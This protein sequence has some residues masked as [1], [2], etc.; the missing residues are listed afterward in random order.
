MTIS[1]ALRVVDDAGQ[2]D[3]TVLQQ[4]I[5]QRHLPLPHVIAPALHSRREM[6][7]Q[8]IVSGKHF[9]RFR[10]VSVVFALV[11][12]DSIRNDGADIRLG[13][14]TGSFAKQSSGQGRSSLVAVPPTGSCRAALGRF[15]STGR[16]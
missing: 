11:R 16:W 1:I 14:G 3:D 5:A 10:P 15:R 4:Q 12:I 6:T 13:Y 8:E 9:H 2:E 7:W